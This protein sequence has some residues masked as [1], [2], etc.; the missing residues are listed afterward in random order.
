MFSANEYPN[1]ESEEE[2][3]VFDNKSQ[4]TNRNNAND[5]KP[6]TRNIDNNTPQIIENMVVPQKINEGATPKET[7]NNGE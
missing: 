3:L 2:E 1:H 4:E 5:N 6:P 7:K